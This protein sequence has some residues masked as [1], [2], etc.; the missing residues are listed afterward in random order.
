MG[1]GF[2]AVSVNAIPPENESRP[3]Q[4][5]PGSVGQ[6][7]PPYRLA[8]DESAVAAVQV[9][10]LELLPVSGD[11]AVLAGKRRITNGDSVRRIAPDG[12]FSA[13]QRKNRT[14]QRTVSYHQPMVHAIRPGQL[15]KPRDSI[16]IRHG[17]VGTRLARL[18][19]RIGVYP[20]G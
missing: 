16:N 18:P 7:N 14:F 9:A 20:I 13:I 2:A 12:E 19:I 1:Y 5:D 6:G 8:I 10:Y 4:R 15:A 11:D 3:A 17:M